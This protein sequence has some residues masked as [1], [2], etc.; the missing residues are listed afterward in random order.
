MFKV[1]SGVML[2]FNLIIAMEFLKCIE[3]EM[4]IDVYYEQSWKNDVLAHFIIWWILY[5]FYGIS[6]MQRKL[7]EHSCSSWAIMEETV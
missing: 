7:L 4:R 3:N 1:I 6:A 2:H 5:H